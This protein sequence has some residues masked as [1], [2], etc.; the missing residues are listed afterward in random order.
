MKIGQHIWYNFIKIKTFRERGL[1]QQNRE[2]LQQSQR[3]NGQ[4]QMGKIIMNK[5]F[6]NEIKI[7]QENQALNLNGKTMNRDNFRNK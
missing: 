1:K 5:I 7:Y 6:R 2:T 4:C 3:Q